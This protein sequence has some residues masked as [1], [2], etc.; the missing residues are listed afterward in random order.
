MSPE[1]TVATRRSFRGEALA[2]ERGDRLLFEGVH[3]TL[4]P[5][6][7][8]QVAG[9]NGCGKTSLLRILCGLSTPLQ[10]NVYWGE[11]PIQRIDGGIGLCIGYLGHQNALKEDLTCAENIATAGQLNELDPDR[12]TVIQMLRRLGLQGYEDVPARFLSQ[13]QKRRVALSRLLL[14]QLPL[15]IL[16]EPYAA[17]DIQVID[18]LRQALENHLASGGMII[19]TDRKSVV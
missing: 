3:F 1:Q 15:W 18:V 16:D 8:L 2:A 11:E 9:R 19:L 17:L 4:F 14:Q 7:L 13:G 12:A 10:G 5:G 6:Q